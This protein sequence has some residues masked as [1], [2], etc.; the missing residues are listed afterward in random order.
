MKKDD[1][2]MRTLVANSIFLYFLVF[3][4]SAYVLLDSDL[5]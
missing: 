4:M 5:V 1:E 2:I 3:F